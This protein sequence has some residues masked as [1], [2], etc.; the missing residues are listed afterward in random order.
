MTPTPLFHET[1][2]DALR[3]VVQAYGGAK[4]VGAAMKP[5]KAADDAGRWVLDCLNPERQ[6]RFDP[7]EVLWLLREGRKIG[8]H[9]AALFLMRESGYADPVPVEPEDERARLEREFID[10]ARSVEAIAARMMRMGIKVAA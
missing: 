1:L 7:E 8:C 4:K 5:Q 3:E 9:A 10:A 6:A 2:T